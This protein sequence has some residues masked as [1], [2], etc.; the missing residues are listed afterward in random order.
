MIKQTLK[1]RALIVDDEPFARERVRQLLDGDPEIEI[2]GECGDGLQAIAM[3]N[4]QA[5]DLLFLDVQMPELDGFELLEKVEAARMPVIIFLTAYD[6]YAIRAFEACALDYLLK[7]C[8]EDRFA[9]SVRRAKALLGLSPEEC[10][11]ASLLSLPAPPEAPSSEQ[12]FLERLVVK[13][14]GRVYF[15]RV[16]EID[17]I[18]AQGNYARIYVDRAA[19]LLR[20][21]LSHLER[22]LDPRRFVRIHRS[23]IV[24]VDRIKELQP[25]FHGQYTVV[26][27][28]GAEITLSRRYRRQFEAVIGRPF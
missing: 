2:A 13:S 16:E 12:K 20:E 9:K 27:R 23:T 5:P 6:Q 14:G 8:A 24:N 1:I 15:F 19:Y 3:I 26:L 10:P 7:P 21:P 28:D 11:P 17:W 4:E 25:M 18:E 22:A